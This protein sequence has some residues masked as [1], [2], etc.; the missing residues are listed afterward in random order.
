MR[1]AAFITAALLLSNIAFAAPKVGAPAPDFAATD[2]HGKTVRLSD[3]RGKLVVLEWTNAGCP[4]VQKHYQGNMQALQQ[5]A[6]IEGAVWLSIVSS[7][8]GNPRRSIARPPAETTSRTRATSGGGAPSSWHNV[9][10]AMTRSGAESISVPS[11][12]NST[13]RGVGSALMPVSSRT[14]DS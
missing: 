10:T 6:T 13:A 12:S 14:R 1:C 2:S 11:R 4:F 8:P 7:A 3:Y 9:S 5:Q